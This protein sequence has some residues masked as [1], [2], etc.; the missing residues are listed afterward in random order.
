LQENETKK[1]AGIYIRVS[2]EDQAREGFSL[3]EQKERLEA[4]CKYK[5]YKVYKIYED[6]GISAKTG[7]K[8]PAYDEMLEDMKQGKINT[9]VALKLDRLSRSVY[10]WENLMKFLEDN[11]GYI[12]CANDEINTTNANGK[13]VSRLLM[14]VSQNEIE[15]TSERTKIGLVGAAKNGHFSGKAPLG[16][17]KINKKLVTNELEAIVIKRIFSLYIQGNSV[18]SIVK[19]FNEEKVLNRK[20]ATTSVDL[21]LSNYIYAGNYQHKKR[22]KG[23]ETIL[24]ENVCPAIVDKLTFDIVQRQKEKNQKN[25]KRKHIYIFMQSIVCSKCNKIMGGSSSTSKSKKKHIYYKCNCCNTRINE[26]KIEKPL[27]NFLNDMLDYFLLIDNTY[28]P[29][30]NQDI[31]LKLKKYTKIYDELE[32]KRKKLKLAFIDDDMN[33]EIFKS[34]YDLII[35]QKKEMEQKINELKSSNNAL[36][37]RDDLRLIHN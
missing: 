37:N 3:E 8:R 15:R 6:A 11:N 20:W 36:D 1:T 26:K 9:I 21:I 35:S 31:D 2:T 10:D 33:I 4:M 12:D 28:K 29:Y 27:L 34:D 16:Y 14:S 25:F 7:N 24:L 13:L 30:L 32:K 22:I 5:G 19:L 18:C 23:E 17:D